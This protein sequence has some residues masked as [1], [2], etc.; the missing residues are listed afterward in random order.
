[1]R[2]RERAAMVDHTARLRENAE[3]VVLGQIP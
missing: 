1:L 2:E 3:I